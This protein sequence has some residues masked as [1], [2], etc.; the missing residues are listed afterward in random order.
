MR[1]N[2]LIRRVSRRAGLTRMRLTRNEL[3]LRRWTRVVSIRV[4]LTPGRLTR[5]E[6]IRKIAIRLALIQLECRILTAFSG[7]RG[8][9]DVIFRTGQFS[10]SFRSGLTLAALGQWGLI[11]VVSIRRGLIQ[12]TLTLGEFV[13]LTLIRVGSTRQVSTRRA[14]IQW[15]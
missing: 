8:P 4:T 12:L 7:L 13:R 15:G 14:L 3:C 1:R 9:R 10:G 5:R 2:R 11:H 6:L